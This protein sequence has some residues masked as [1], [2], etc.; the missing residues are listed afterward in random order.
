[1]ITYKSE[2]VNGGQ[3]IILP[4]LAEANRLGKEWVEAQLAKW[5]AKDPKAKIKV[6]YVNRDGKPGK[7]KEMNVSTFVDRWG[8]QEKEFDGCVADITHGDPAYKESITELCEKLV[9][10]ASEIEPSL[11]VNYSGF[12]RS[13]DGIDALPKLVAQRD[14]NPYPRRKNGGDQVK[15]G[16]GQGAYRIIINTDI[17][18]WGQPTD[19]AG[20]MGALIVVLS[21]FKPVEVW[22]QQGWMGPDDG[23]GV[24]MFKLDFTGGFDPTQLA[25]WCGHPK[26]DAVYSYIL[27]RALNR[28]GSNTS[29][30]AE[31]EC[32]LYVRGDYM[33]SIGI[34]ESHQFLNLLHTD[35][36]D[37]MA[38]WIAATAMKIAM[39][40]G[41]EEQGLDIAV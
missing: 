20:M 14:E 31:I 9:D 33:N 28:N 39:K 4:S 26:K 18:W 10:L 30:T 7:A 24:T 41:E 32:D 12:Q 35:R 6:G 21:R 13:E 36:V 23:D 29:T 17:S 22:V 37:L 3:T 38:K 25:F 16:T 1:M 8:V 27:S 2:T 5:R 15:D 34:T 40:N 19:A 11:S